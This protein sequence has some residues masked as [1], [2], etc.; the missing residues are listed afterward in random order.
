[1]SISIVTE[2]AWEDPS[3][4]F[5][6]RRRRFTPPPIPLSPLIGRDGDV[7]AACAYLRREDV[8]LLTLTGAGGI[9]KT[10]LAL[11]VAAEVSA[12]PD[13]AD[14]APDFPDGVA[15]IPL[16]SVRDPAAVAG[17]VA[18]GIGAADPATGSVV[19]AVQASLRDARALLVLDNFEQVLD[20]APFLSELLG[21]CPALKVLVTSR[22]LLRIN[23]EHALATPPLSLLGA[24]EAGSDAVRLFVARARALSGTFE[25]T[26]ATGAV[27]SDICQRLDGLP[28]AIELAA[29]RADHLPLTTL[30]DRIGEWS[31]QAKG[32]RDLPDRQRTLGAAIAWSYDLLS[33]GQQAFFRR[34]A[35]FSGGFTLD[36]AEAIAG[37]AVDP[38]DGIDTL[39]ALVD[40]NLVRR[41][42]AG[43]GEQRYGLLNTIQEFAAERLAGGGEG[44]AARER[45]AAFF[46]ERVEHVAPDRRG[47]ARASWLAQQTSELANLRA[48]T[49][50]SL[51]RGRADPVLRLVAAMETLYWSARSDPGEGLRWIEAA[52]AIDGSPAARLEAF[53]VASGLAALCGDLARAQAFGEEALAQGEALGQPRE[54]ARA[55]VCIGK[56]AEWRG[57]LGEAAARYAAA[58]VAF[59][60]L[61]DPYWIA[62]MLNNRAAMALGTGDLP[63]AESLAN[64]ALA[65]WRREADAWGVAL[66][67]GT[68]GGVVQAAG[69]L[70]RAG[71]LYLEALDLGVALDDRRS[72]AST[73]VGMAGVTVA[74]GRLEEAARLLGAA[75]AMRDALGSAHL[76]HDF[77]YAG[78]L[79][80]VGSG[81][82]DGIFA[83]AWGAGLG[84]TPEQAIAAMA[85]EVAAG[86]ELETPPGDAAPGEAPLLSPREQEVLRLL[87]RGMTDRAIAEA[88]FVGERTVNSHVGKIYAKLGVRSRAAAVTAAIGAGLVEGSGGSA[89][90]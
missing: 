33:P 15:W 14:R 26:G 34:L 10:R 1:M 74:R 82:P 29:S 50:W 13:A 89:S 28:L 4:L 37:G 11:R 81:L 39:A 78:V 44:D 8:R 71:G 30:R 41:E 83:T 72:I 56:A 67:L 35:V 80:T 32:A 60:A 61:D 42:P 9:G 64:E 43:D 54:A 70:P 36:A 58:L 86:A 88:L 16:A 87:V 7:A 52:L 84:W 79:E 45:H 31:L 47:A 90:L 51:E 25:L 24:G 20:A 76:P 53:L 68:L 57:D 75:T 12:R 27:V 59:R 46:L 5:L 3:P 62:L 77:R 18:R 63:G 66:A 65:C 17:E 22:S 21:R 73:L 38:G 19:E 69:D 48:A 6:R 40:M 23:G 49:R 2:Q 55:L 85:A